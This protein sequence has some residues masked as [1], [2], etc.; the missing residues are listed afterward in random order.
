V[1]L[2]RIVGSAAA[3]VVLAVAVVPTVSAATLPA[4]K[5]VAR[6][7]VTI[8]TPDILRVDKQNQTNNLV[9]FAGMDA[10]VK[11]RVNWGDSDP[12]EQVRGN[13]KTKT[14]IAHPDWCSV[15]VVHQ[16]D[17]PGQYTI[18]AI[19]GKTK[20]SK[21]VTISPTPVR[22]SPP[23]GFAQPAGWSLLGKQATYFP[24]QTIPWYYDRT[25]QPGNGGQIY[26]DTVTSLAMLSAETGLVFTETTDPA[27]AALTFRW[28]NV[29]TAAGTGG[30]A[31]GVGFVNFSTTDWWPTDPWPGFA[32]V[33]QPNGVFAAGHGWLVVHEV[34][35]AIGI[36]HVNDRT[37]VMN[38]VGGAIAFNAGDLDALHT[39]YKNNPCPVG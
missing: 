4:A 23:A 7:A 18:T 21:L 14:A 11:A 27:Q 8:V 35:H 33:R 9:L 24:C 34:M 36:G 29:G 19:A 13:C 6:P 37:S 12:T 28:A 5:P 16:Y 39:M 15:A 26:S 32:I 25:S 2:L 22:W 38:P 10:K 31:N 20:V 3:A 17:T 30:G 1:R